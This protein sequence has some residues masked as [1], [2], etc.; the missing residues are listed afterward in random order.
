MFGIVYD[1]EQKASMNRTNFSY[2]PSE[3]FPPTDTPPIE[4]GSLTMAP[5]TSTIMGITW[6]FVSKATSHVPPTDLLEPETKQVGP[7]TCQMIKQ[8]LQ[9]ILKQARTTDLT[10][11]RISPPWIYG[12]NL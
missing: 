10:T 4:A 3:F 5:R 2:L 11:I 7:A 1:L 6:E 9:I 12:N 8:G